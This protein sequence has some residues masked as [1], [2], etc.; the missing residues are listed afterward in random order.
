MGKLMFGFVVFWAYMGF[1]QYMLIWYANI[2]EE[3]V[4]FYVRWYN[5]WR[6]VSLVLIFGHFALPFLV[7]ITRASK[8]HLAIL[9]G[10]AIWLLAMRWFDLHWLAMPNLHEQGPHFSWLDFTSLAGIG[11]IFVWYFWRQYTSHPIVPVGD[12]TLDNSIKFL[13]N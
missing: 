6:W 10:S 9:G 4:W 5:D 13:N 2:P 3:T 11:G 7:L 1:S 8:R 12:P